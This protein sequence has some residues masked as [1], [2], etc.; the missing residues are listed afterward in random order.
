MDK[1]YRNGV[2]IKVAFASASINS[3]FIEEAVI[4][5]EKKFKVTVKVKGFFRKI[6]RYVSRKLYHPF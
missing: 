5:V 6:G 3:S 2:D 1:V 4:P